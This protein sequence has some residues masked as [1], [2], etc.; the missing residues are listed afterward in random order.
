MFSPDKNS[1]KG[2]YHDLELT[3]S[4]LSGHEL[5]RSRENGPIFKRS[6]NKSHKRFF[7]KSF[8]FCAVYFIANLHVN[9]HVCGV[10][11][12]VRV[13]LWKRSENAVIF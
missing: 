11:N 12:K 4:D 10:N 7:Q 1:R 9:I 2:K 13:I 6:L 5:S 3:E 8:L